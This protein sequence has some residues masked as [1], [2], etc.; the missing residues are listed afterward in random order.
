MSRDCRCGVLGREAAEKLQAL[1]VEQGLDLVRVLQISHIGGHKVRSAIKLIPELCTTQQNI[2]N[3]AS[4][5]LQHSDLLLPLCCLVIAI[6]NIH[7]AAGCK[8]K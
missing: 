6:L 2:C 8:C 5:T 7:H 1:A 3:P 4:S